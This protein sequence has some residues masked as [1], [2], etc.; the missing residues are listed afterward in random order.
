M[1]QTH[2]WTNPVP[3]PVEPGTKGVF[4]VL[5][6]VPNLSAKRF[7][8]PSFDT[9]YYCGKTGAIVAFAA[10]G[11]A[12]YFASVLNEAERDEFRGR[13]VRHYLEQRR[14]A[15]HGLTTERFP[16]HKVRSHYQAVA[17]QGPEAVTKHSLHDALIAA[18]I[19]DD[20]L[21]DIEDRILMAAD[22]AA[23]EIQIGI[24]A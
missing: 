1:T 6:K 7:C 8:G 4:A 10:L 24:A 2:S 22:P 17:Y 18:W 16:N 11:D 21:A 19:L 5:C 9:P 3:T 12:M 15:R 14:K 20:D 13:M 23:M